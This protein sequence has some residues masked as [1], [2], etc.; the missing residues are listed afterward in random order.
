MC[1]AAIDA[2][3]G[4]LVVLEYPNRRTVEVASVGPLELGSEFE[5]YGRRWQAVKVLPETRRFR[6]G[7]PT[8]ILCRSI[9]RV[10]SFELDPRD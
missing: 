8:R 3:R 2:E 1:M 7:E 10:V 9:A 5:L 4:S 6:P